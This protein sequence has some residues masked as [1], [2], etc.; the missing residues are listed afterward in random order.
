MA[1]GHIYKE[2]VLHH[3]IYLEGLKPDRSSLAQPCSSFPF[4]T[5]RRDMCGS[6]P[7]TV[8]LGV[9]NGSLAGFLNSTSSVTEEGPSP[10]LTRGMW[11]CETSQSPLQSH[12]HIL[13]V[14]A[15]GCRR[16]CDQ[17]FFHKLQPHLYSGS[18]C[19]RLTTT[20]NT[21]PTCRLP[22][23]PSPL[24]LCIWFGSCQLHW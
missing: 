18:G 12:P 8:G 9:A 6:N 5:N 3:I 16:Q 13:P 14:P 11:V 7:R 4:P 10:I 22:V 1:H 21:W 17:T 24:C 2:V 19:G 15:G 23:G 20:Q